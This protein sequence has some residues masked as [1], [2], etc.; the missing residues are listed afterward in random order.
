VEKASFKFL[1][2]AKGDESSMDEREA[3]GRKVK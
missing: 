1:D 3:K 2:I